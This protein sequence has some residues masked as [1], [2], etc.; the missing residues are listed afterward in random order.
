[1]SKLPFLCYTPGEGSR[2]ELTVSLSHHHHH[3]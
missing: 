2:F 1:V 3:Q